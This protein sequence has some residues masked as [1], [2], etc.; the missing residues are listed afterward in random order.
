MTLAFTFWLEKCTVNGLTYSP[1]LSYHLFNYSV[2]S[3]DDLFV[4]Y[5]LIA[6]ASLPRLH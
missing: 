2:I 5:K 6:A 4:G 3:H 1:T